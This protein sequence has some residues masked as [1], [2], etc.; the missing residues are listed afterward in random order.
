MAH[1]GEGES[2]LLLLILERGTRMDEAPHHIKVAHHRGIAKRRCAHIVG[3]VDRR[4]IRNE[5]IHELQLTALGR[6]VQ[7]SVAAPVPRVQVDPT[8]LE[9]GERI[10]GV[11]PDSSEQDTGVHGLLPAVK[12]CTVLREIPNDFEVAHRRR[13]VHGC[14]PPL[15][16]HINGRAMLNQP[17]HHISLPRARR[18]E[19]GGIA[20]KDLLIDQRVTVLL[21]QRGSSVDVACVDRVPE[22]AV[23]RVV[24]RSVLLPRGRRRHGRLL[25]LPGRRVD[26]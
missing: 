2:A 21:H 16:G 17:A 4:A 6:V 15:V 8:S 19:E 26:P 25:V 23:W 14:V 13:L 18:L 9:L 7:R 5:P 10:K 22:A 12:V 24:R 11:V 3:G 1:G 20:V